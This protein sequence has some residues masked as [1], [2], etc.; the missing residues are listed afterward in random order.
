LTELARKKASLFVYEGYLQGQLQLYKS[1]LQFK[2]AG[3]EWPFFCRRLSF[4]FSKRLKWR[5]GEPRRRTASAIVYLPVRSLIFNFIRSVVP[6]T[7]RPI[8]YLT[9]LARKRTHS[10]V[11]SGIF[12]GMRYVK[13]AVCSAYIPKLI[14][15]YE[16]ELVD[17][18]EEICLM[19]P[20]VLVDIGAAEGYYAVG[21]ARRL[22]QARVIAFEMESLGRQ[23]LADM[24]NLNGVAERLTIHGKCVEADLTEIAA[25]HPDAVYIIDVEGNEE[26]LLSSIVVPVLSKASI[27][28]ELHEFIHSGITDRLINRFQHSHVIKVIWQ[29]PR[30]FTEFPWKTVYARLLPKS[31]LDWAVSEWRPI[32][33][34]WLWMKPKVETQ[35][36]TV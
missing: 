16:R 32:R 25:K 10:C 19:N 18:V 28:V 35:K 27:L 13:T 7:L 33:M 3:R 26:T 23:A 21:L 34:N 11:D 6:E 20:S 5:L 12:E 9:Q 1:S 14:G 24:A 2:T 4:G 30:S 31:Y 29:E 22:P 17:A 15:I 36:V 8:G